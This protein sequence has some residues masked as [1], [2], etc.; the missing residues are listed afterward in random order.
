[1]ENEQKV[2]IGGIKFS[3]ELIQITVASKTPD[4]SCITH[5]LH[6]IAEKNINISFFTH[7]V[8]T[9]T[10]ESIFCVERTELDAIKEILKHTSFTDEHVSIIESVGTLTLFPH[11]NELKLLG[12]IINFFGNCSFP[13]HSFC[14]SI[15]AI[16]VNTEYLLLDNIAENLQSIV[17]LP[18]NHAPFRQGFRVTQIQQ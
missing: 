10:P 11:R 18:D 4:D 2:R 3:E 7:S 13:V 12:L 5:L 15:S 9:K 6:L 17:L 1:M 14:T 8:Y 16:A